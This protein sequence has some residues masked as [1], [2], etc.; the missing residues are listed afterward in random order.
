MAAMSHRI[1]NQV[2]MASA[3]YTDPLGE[4]ITPFMQAR[5][6]LYKTTSF[7]D[8]ISPDDPEDGTTAFRGSA[9]CRSGISLSVRQT[10]R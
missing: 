3:P 5:A 8:P 4:V 9:R 6:D 10:H 2:E 1:I 7:N